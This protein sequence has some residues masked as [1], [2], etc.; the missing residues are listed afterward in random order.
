MQTLTFFED[1][2]S[3]NQ[4]NDCII[5]SDKTLV[6]HINCKTKPQSIEWGHAFVQETEEVSTNAVS[7]KIHG[8]CILGCSESDFVVFLEQIDDTKQVS[9]KTQHEMFVSP[10]QRSSRQGQL[11]PIVLGS[12]QSPTLR[13]GFDPEQ[14]PHF[15]TDTELHAGVN[16][17]MN[18]QA[19][20]FYR[21]GIEKFKN[22]RTNVYDDERIGRPSIEIDEIVSKVDEK[23]KEEC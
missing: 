6:K 18:S 13:S 16:Q 14:L 8:D 12:L 20:D 11:Y 3:R 10:R 15:V 17:W 2:K 23:T 4:V 1:D 22:G 5:T 9:G 7:K 19:T 21:E